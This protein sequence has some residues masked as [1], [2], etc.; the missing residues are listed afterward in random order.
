M[1]WTQF[2]WEGQD[3]QHFVV[4]VLFAEY[5][6]MSYQISKK[7]S[8]IQKSKI[9]AKVLHCCAKRAPT[10]PQRERRRFARL[11]SRNSQSSVLFELFFENILECCP[12]WSYHLSKWCPPVIHRATFVEKYKLKAFCQIFMFEWP[13]ISHKLLHTWAHTYFTGKLKTLCQNCEC[14]CPISL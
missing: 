5:M 4:K 9:G 13:G 7:R 6:S 8:K 11:C 2:M 10:N 14:L 3:S 12:M 1:S